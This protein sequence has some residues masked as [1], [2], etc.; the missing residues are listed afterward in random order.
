M[1]KF[2]QTKKVENFIAEALTRSTVNSSFEITNFCLFQ[3][4]II[5]QGS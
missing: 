1:R 2:T 3:C 5:A 4:Q